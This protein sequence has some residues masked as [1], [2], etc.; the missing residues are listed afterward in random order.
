MRS[1]VLLWTLVL[2][3]LAAAGLA[4]WNSGA[5][6][7]WF[8]EGWSAHAAAQPDLLSAAHA[9]ATN[10]PLYYALLHVTARVWGDSEFGLRVTSLLIGL[11]GIAAAARWARSIQGSRG[12]VLT[13]FVMVFMPLLWW[14][15]REARMYTLLMLLVLLAVLALERLRRGPARWAWVLL[16]T[17]ELAA[18][19]THNTGPVIALW[20]N[21]L[22]VLAWLTG[23][24]PLQPRPLAW[25]GSQALVALLWLPYFVTRFAA[26]PSANSGLM[27]SVDLSPAG[28]FALWQG[29][30]QTPWER[31]LF[32]NESVLPFALLLALF[33]ALVAVRWRAA[34]WPLLSALILLAGVLAGL[35]LLGNEP[36]SRY[37]V[38]AVPF[39]AAAWGGAVA[40]FRRTA[41]RVAL[42]IPPLALFTAN[43][44]TNTA[45]EAPFQRDD[46][47]AMVQFYADA[48]GPNDSVLAWSYADR[49]ELAYYW[50]RLGVA[51]QRVTLPE[52]AGREE[53]LPLLPRSGAAA[54]NVWYTQRADFRG[55]LDCL[56][57]DGS[58][59]PPE[60]VTV[61]GMSSR[62]YRSIAPQVP[63]MQ[64]ADAVFLAGGQPQAALTAHG[65]LTERPADRALCLPLE[66]DVLAPTTGDLKAAVVVL[67]A[68]G[69]E[70]AR[71]DAVFATADQSTASVL[72]AGETAEAYPLLRLPAGAPPG[73]YP[74]YLRVYDEVNEP[75][76]LIPQSGE[77][78]GR[79][80][81][82]GEWTV[83]P[84]AAWAQGADDSGVPLVEPLVVSADLSLIGHTGVTTGDLP[85]LRNGDR[86]ALT[87]L[88]AGRGTL[89][90]LTLA[91]ADGRWTVDLPAPGGAHDALTRDWREAII[92]ASA[93][94]GEAEARLPD[95]TV[96]AR[97]VVEALPMQTAVPPLDAES[98]AVFPGVGVLVG[99][100]GP[101]TAISL[102]EPP[103]VTLV[104]GAGESPVETSYTV[105][106]QLLDAAGRVIAQS[107]A[108]PGGGARPTT[109]WRAGEVIED[110]HT[111]Q[112]NPNVAPGEA[113]LIAGL[114][115]AATGQRVP[116]ADGTDYALLGPVTVR[117]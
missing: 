77:I 113:V 103:Q 93:E 69:D 63:V 7:L 42:M 36:H 80:V 28:L 30:W 59:S 53:I 52:G 5:Q 106:V 70:I 115:D 24:R 33:A 94:S 47:R 56:I 51:A 89:P 6:S 92:P 58:A 8:D 102:G 68:L 100:D 76:G 25:L 107:D 82:I 4:L 10:P 50:D 71:A 78:R 117:P 79:D 65:T 18:L 29:F 34:W 26:L 20:L 35:L 72:A 11:L 40:K 48:L 84:G 13:A 60:V 55:M 85:V 90:A 83:L 19:Y 57:A 66:L 116:L 96:I 15:M 112:W 32:G 1:R 74:V 61:H 67:N 108:L 81:L 43:F 49:Y 110:T 64:A 109:G 14:A 54:I 101:G 75:S 44:I 2:L 9:D 97:W 39:V 37:L 104:W 73:T 22:V 17:V 105:F 62:L 12:A 45:P 88:W 87:L 31:V 16:V 3:L 86:A 95:G 21:A 27:S 111:L 23:R 99:R 41:V 46:A 98:G 114:Y 91:D 38:I